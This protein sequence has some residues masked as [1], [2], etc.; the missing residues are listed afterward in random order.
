MGALKTL[1]RVLACLLLF[2]EAR[3]HALTLTLAW[4]PSVD[5]SVVGYVLSY[6]TASGSY[7]TQLDAGNSSSIVVANLDDHSIYYFPVQSYDIAQHLSP[8]SA[9]VIYAPLTVTCLN[10]SGTSS[11]GNPVAV[12]IPAPI[13]SGAAPPLTVSC[14][15]ASGSAFSVG[16]TSFQCTVIDV[17]MS[18]SCAGTVTV[19]SNAGGG[20]GSTPDGGGG[21]TPPSGGGSSAPS[22]PAPSPSG[23]A[24]P[25][26]S[27]PP[28]VAADGPSYEMPPPPG[29]FGFSDHGYF[30]PDGGWQETRRLSIGGAPRAVAPSGGGGCI[31]SAGVPVYENPAPAGAF[32][33]SDHGYYRPDG[34]WQETRQIA[35]AGGSS[36][37]PYVTTHVGGGS[38][39]SSPSVSIAAMPSDYDTPPPPG[40]YGFTDR[41]YFR[42]DGGWQSATRLRAGSGAV[43]PSASTNAV[44]NA[45]I[46][47]PVAAPSAPAYAPPPE[48]TRAIAMSAPT[49]SAPA[50]AA[51]PTTPNV[52]V[53]AAP[54][55]MQQPMRY[56]VGTTA[57]RADSPA[58]ATTQ[59][60]TVREPAIAVGLM[61]RRPAAP[62]NATPIDTSLTP[63]SFDA[64][65]SVDP[66]ADSYDV[67]LGVSP[68]PALF[69]SGV[70]G[71]VVKIQGLA[72]NTTYYWRVVARNAAGET[73]SGTWTFTTRSR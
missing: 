7:T 19:S 11:D 47:Y 2:G 45:P 53:Y 40:S 43:Y 14:S 52:Q 22:N 32:G 67:Y 62:S 68:E 44:Y 46:T 49:T 31:P 70:I 26:P 24:P 34:G 12:S 59:T 13:V 23:S 17:V 65:W 15:P 20:G 4:D 29:S 64:S 51:A 54:A 57:V 50:P 38:S 60:T 66:N 21:S 27:A 63:I 10:A 16:S 8:R 6:G 41:G 5:P 30:R 69:K 61:V 1:A 18:A 48:P 3:A 33:F 72:P 28:D 36:C 71:S 25:A 56:D 35:A 73:A 55:A 58:P 37:I 42:P 39:S 9:E